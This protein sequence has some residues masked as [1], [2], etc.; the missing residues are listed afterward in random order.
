MNLTRVMHPQNERNMRLSRLRRL[1]YHLVPFYPI[2]IVC[3]GDKGIGF[4]S[5]V[6]AFLFRSVHQNDEHL[7]HYEAPRNPD[8][9]SRY[10]SNVYVS[11]RSLSLHIAVPE[12]MDVVVF[13]FF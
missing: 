1:R 7:R 4:T 12:S 6:I 9:V 2:R 11:R 10:H 5:A 3:I 13:F 8:D